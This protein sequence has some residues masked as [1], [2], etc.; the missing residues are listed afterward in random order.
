MNNKSVLT[1][2]IHCPLV[3]S[4]A[5]QKSEDL[6][7]PRQ[8]RRRNS[9]SSLYCKARDEA[10]AQTK[11]GAETKHLDAEKC[12]LVQSHLQ[13]LTMQTTVNEDIEHMEDEAERQ[14]IEMT[15]K[16]NAVSKLDE[17]YVRIIER[18]EE[19]KRDVQRT[20]DNLVSIINAKKETIFAAVEDQTKKSL[21]SLTSQKT[22]IE[23]QIEV[24]KS[25]LDK[26]EAD[27]ALTRSANPEVVQVKKSLET[28]VEGVD[29]TT[30]PTEVD[31]KGLPILVFVENQKMLE[32]VNIE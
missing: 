29:Q 17:D 27:K 7:R 4:L 19:V 20:F 28:I 30:K 21:E 23:H 32:T 11:G 12:E 13:T 25:L 22:E 10:T 14:K 1:R 31:P 8:R 24:V 9:D 18:G 5:E 26:L 3:L 2:S 6:E 15:S 16:I